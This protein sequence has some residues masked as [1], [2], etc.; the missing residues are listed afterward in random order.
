MGEES[1]GYA[2]EAVVDTLEET[3]QVKL[4]DNAQDK[5]QALQTIYTTDSFYHSIPAFIAI[6]DGLSGD[7][8]DFETADMPHVADMAW[9]VMEAFLNMPPEQPPEELFSDDVKAFI[10]S[11][12]DVEGFSRSPKI[13][14]F[15]GNFVPAGDSFMDDE[16]IYGAHYSINADLIK[17]V[18]DYIGFK[19]RT[20]L[21]IISSLPLRNRD[22]KSWG[23][24]VTG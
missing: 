4:P 19:S 7:G 18:D 23:K 8:T 24:L 6:A 3:Y 10:R 11:V 5:I 12:L 22:K 16:M 20:I 1:L 2:I 13:L 21:D 15:A 14:K 17:D 9:A